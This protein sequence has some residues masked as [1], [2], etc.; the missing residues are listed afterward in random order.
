MKKQ[1]TVALGLAVLATPV[2]ASKARLQAL[3]E[4]TNGSFYINDNRNVFLNP[5]AVNAHSDLVTYEWGQDVNSATPDTTATP[6]AEGGFFKSHGSFNYGVQLGRVLSSQNGFEKLGNTYRPGNAIDLFVGGDAGI[7]W[8]AQATYQKAYDDANKD[9]THT[10]DLALGATQGNLSGF[11]NYGIG[12]KAE[13]NNVEVK[14]K[15][16]YSIG[17]SYKM[18]GMTAFGQYSRAEFEKDNANDDTYTSTGWLLGVG[19]EHK[20][21][22]KT[23]MFT[24]LS[25]SQFTETL[26][27]GATTTR[28]VPVTIGFEHDVNSWMVLRGSVAQNLW[29]SVRAQGGDKSNVANTTVVNAGA[30]LKFGDLNVD[31]V[32]GNNSDAT[33]A[34]LGAST[35]AGKGQLRTDSLMSRVS[36]TYRF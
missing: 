12:A 35:A 29:S 32:V 10:Y 16:T 8:G 17:G 2:F 24:R 31:G 21:T 5:E 23:V 7:K 14:R 22:D 20:L 19:R 34:G 18:M 11:I 9:K 33:N 26:P 28:A 3:G 15:G 36:V 13:D 4:S 27:A 1:L 25:G 30:T 6:N